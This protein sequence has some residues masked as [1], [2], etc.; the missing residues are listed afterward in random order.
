MDTKHGTTEKI[1]EPTRAPEVTVIDSDED[2]VAAE[3]IGG[4][5]ADLPPG[6]Y[7]SPSFIGTI[8]VSR[9]TAP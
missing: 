6:Y 7:R 5:N 2:E 9:S 4:T 8:V 1:E 3:A